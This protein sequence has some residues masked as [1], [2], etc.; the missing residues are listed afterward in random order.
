MKKGG[1]VAWNKQKGAAFACCL[2]I[3]LHYREKL[4]L[5]SRRVQVPALSGRRTFGHE[6]CLL[7]TRKRAKRRLR[8]LILL[9]ATGMYVFQIPQ[10]Q[11]E[12]LYLHTYNHTFSL[13]EFIHL[14]SLAPAEKEILISEGLPV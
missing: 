12:R 8:T 13:C 10:E 11:F 4:P 6:R 2:F 9:R 7:F 1:T 5:P 14:S 3:R